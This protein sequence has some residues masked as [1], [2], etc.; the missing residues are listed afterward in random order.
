M[1]DF[2]AYIAA[3]HRGLNEHERALDLEWS[4]HQS[5]LDRHEAELR[6][7]LIVILLALPFGE[8]GRL[9]RRRM[10]EVRRRRREANALVRRFER[11]ALEHFVGSAAEGF[12]DENHPPAG[13][14]AWSFFRARATRTHQTATV[15]AYS[16]S[17]SF[18]AQAWSAHWAA[19]REYFARL[20]G[21]A[22]PGTQTPGTGPFGP[23]GRPSGGGPQ[24]PPSGGAPRPRPLLPGPAN[25]TEDQKRERLQRRPLNSAELMFLEEMRALGFDPPADSFFDFF[26]WYWDNIDAIEAARR[27]YQQF[28]EDQPEES[29]LAEQ[30][31]NA[32][33][34]PAANIEYESRRWVEQLK[35]ATLGGP[36]AAEL[37]EHINGTPFASATAG[38]H[39]R[40][41]G[42]AMNRNNMR[43]STEAH[44]RGMFR[45][46]IVRAFEGAGIDQFLLEYPLS[47]RG[48]IT[49][50]GLISQHAHM[51]RPLDEWRE[52]IRGVNLEKRPTATFEGGGLHHG[53]FTVPIPV[54]GIWTAEAQNYSKA[55]RGKLARQLKGAA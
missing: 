10:E 8:R 23:S 45:S 37:I 47:R 48:S 54:P 27:L 41:A 31:D 1:P 53:D 33:S 34:N 55:A 52:V 12:D 36:T 3:T 7:A 5:W 24:L 32:I 2:D 25:E 14:D 13:S 18:V 44:V 9:N 20:T 22:G 38:A 49:P 6:A 50:S 28:L 26:N 16:R 17:T 21:G 29:W 46:N 43:L 40:A 11:D 39:K 35:D 4:R 30:L 51:L 19:W 15:D 42:I